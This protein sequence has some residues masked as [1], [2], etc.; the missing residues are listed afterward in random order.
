[1]TPWASQSRLGPCGRDSK[2]EFRWGCPDVPRYV[3]EVQRW[4]RG[5]GPPTHL[6]QRAAA[7]PVPVHVA[8]LTSQ[9]V[10]LAGELADGIMPFLWPAP[11]VAQSKAWAD[12]G[13][14]KATGRRPLEI[15][16]GLPTFIGNDV[17]AQR[18]V[19]RQNLG[20]YTTLPFFQRLFRAAGFAAEAAKAEQGGRA[21]LPQ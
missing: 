14:A 18:A 12:K 13:R 20:L 8:T 19:A 5:E 21:R 11:R 9:G 10:E 15:T 7:H 6:P 1:V 4:L 17:E 16:L 2:L 3:S